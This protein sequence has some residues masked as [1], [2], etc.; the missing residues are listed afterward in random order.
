MA[1]DKKAAREKAKKAA[2]E[3]KVKRAL[4]GKAAEVHPDAKSGLAKIYGKIYGK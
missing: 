4:K 2:A 3:K 1:D